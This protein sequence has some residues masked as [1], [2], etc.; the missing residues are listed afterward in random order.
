MR[1][2]SIYILLIL[3]LTAFGND[4]FAKDKCFPDKDKSNKTLVYDESDILSDGEE[5]QLNARLID[6]ANSSSN[7]MVVVIVNDLCG[8][9]KARYA[10]KLGHEWGVGQAEFDNGIVLM[11]KPTGK[12]G[13][14]HTYIAVGYG[15][16]G[17][18][19]DATAKMIV[20][21]E[22]LPNFKA[23]KFY[24][25][26]TN[27]TNILMELA[28]GE[29]NSDEYAAKIASRK[30]R[31]ALFALL[32]FFVV[33]GFL[34]FRLRKQVSDYSRTNSIPFWTAFWLISQSGR[35]HGDGFGNFGS[36]SGGFG[37]GGGFGGFGGGGFGGGGAGGSW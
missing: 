36:G 33:F 31:T 24:A 17:A 1:R 21:Y 25:G 18:I 35:S 11:V 5:R 23:E 13:Q 29:Y 4:V 19:P 8:M 26:L 27:A 7:Q 30:T 28:S 16:E 2:R 15:L 32:I 14:R 20:D 12:K 3:F 10:T 37:G 22:L 34:F 9:D 6:F